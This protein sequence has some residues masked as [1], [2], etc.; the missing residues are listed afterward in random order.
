[1]PRTTV[2]LLALLLAFLPVAACDRSHGYRGD[3]TFTDFGPTAAHERYVLDLGPIDLSRPNRQSFKMIGLPPAEFTMGL[4]E[5]NVSAGCDV[6]ALASISVRLDLQV[7]DG[8]VV[9]AEQ[10]PLSEWVSSP[11]LL[12][13]RGQDRRE[14]VGGGAV[15][16][17]PIGIRASGGWGTYFT[18]MSSGTY[19]ARFTVLDARGASGCESRLVLLGG[20]WK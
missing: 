15:R 3:G 6:T 16:F 2:A 9:I 17:V 11:D 18:P 1:M 20:G 8:A 5:V 4:R 19:L 13:R 7:E 14:A 10:A 12:Y